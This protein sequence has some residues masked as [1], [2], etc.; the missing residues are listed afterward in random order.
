M[1]L[2]AQI[3]SDVASVFL[4]PDDFA[5]AHVIDGQPVTCVVSD[6]R[7]GTLS[8]ELDG[9]AY[10]ATR[11]IH[12]APGALAKSPVIGKRLVLD[13]AAYLVLNA[14][15]ELGLLVITI[16]RHTAA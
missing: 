11:T 12:V 1:T 16:T 13:G 2:R 3:A 7:A 4:Q 15:E 14:L 8:G 6:D 5:E 10:L 9:A